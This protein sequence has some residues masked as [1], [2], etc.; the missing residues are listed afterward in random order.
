MNTPQTSGGDNS[1]DKTVT[2]WSKIAALVATVATVVSGFNAMQVSRFETNFKQV[3]AE[4]ELNFRIYSSIASALESQDPKQ[5][6]AVRGIVEAMASES[7]KPAFRQ[8][9][10]PAMQRVFNQEQ[11][12]V[13]TETVAATSTGGQSTSNGDDAGG[14][15][16]DSSGYS[17]GQSST[18]LAWN[19]WDFDIFWCSSSG[20]E[21][22]GLANQISYWLVKDGAKGRVRTRVLPDSIND[23]ASYSVSGIEVRRSKNEAA[24]GQKLAQFV[25]NLS[26]FKDLKV[27]EKTS[28]QNT[29]WYIS[30]FVC[31]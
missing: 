11:L 5:I 18:K 21:A 7:I 20:I 13:P 24:M 25:G 23:R 14:G 4:R 29:P 8:A 12:D 15:G 9:L 10:E 30:V 19:D 22:E 16:S 28:N 6:L 2:R 27:T 1:L 3:E 26:S 31:P 17:K